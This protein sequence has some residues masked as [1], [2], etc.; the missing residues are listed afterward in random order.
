M[1]GTVLTAL[2]ALLFLHGDLGE[3]DY[4]III[5]IFQIRTPRAER[6]EVSSRL[7]NCET[8]ALT[9]ASQTLE[10]LIISLYYFWVNHLDFCCYT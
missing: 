1:A 4:C 9:Q 7:Q 8:R 10:T 6:S 2:Y 3:R 5:T